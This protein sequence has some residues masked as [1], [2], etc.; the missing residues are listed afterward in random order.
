MKVK[1]R[2]LYRAPA[3]K[4]LLAADLSQAESWIVAYLSGGELMKKY[5]LHSDIHSE[6]G[7]EL[8]DKHGDGPCLDEFH[9]W[10]SKGKEKDCTVCHLHLLETE[11]YV[12]KQNNHA[13]SY[14]MGPERQAQVINKQSDKP[15]YV[16]V[17][18]KECRGFQS[19]WHGLYPNVHD[20]HLNIQEELKRNHYLETPYGFKRTFYGR[21]DE[22]LF[23]SAYSFIPQSTV[24][25]HFAGAEQPGR[26]TKIKSGL[27]GVRKDIIGDSK[28]MKIVNMSHD[29]FVMELPEVLLNEIAG[30][31]YNKL[32]RPMEINGESFS[33]PVDVEVG[34]DYGSMKSY[35][36][37]K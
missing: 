30:L 10:V 18:V 1:I 24:C 28:E 19:K 2:S 37:T 13:N 36:I 27:R 34:G 32:F 26:I 25:Y 23:K 16:T 33:I 3:G 15:P 4:I 35:E 31:V 12:G 5:L 20:W 9:N 17:S 11:R 6:T 21:Y 29:S 8:F 7:V 14:G 22:Q